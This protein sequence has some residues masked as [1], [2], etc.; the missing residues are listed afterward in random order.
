MP[1]PLDARVKLSVL[2]IF[3]IA[4]STTPVRAQM[5]FAGYA[6]VLLITALAAR[7]GLKSILLRSAGVLPFTGVF[8]LMVWLAGDSQRAVG[9]LEKSML[10]VIATVIVTTT[11]PVAGIARALAWARIPM[12]LVLVIQ[13][14]HRYLLVVTDEVRSLQRAALSRSGNRGRTRAQFAAAAGSLGVLFAKSW[15][16]ADGIYLAMLARGFRGQFPEFSQPH[17][18]V[19]DGALLG[20]GAAVLA[21]LRALA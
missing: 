6:L 5:V 2:L 8:A 12:P 18:C 13:F 1:P 9:L 3:L 10:S 20:G 4:V 11:T 17:F 15:Q 19:R 21:A 16:R 14:L 7:A